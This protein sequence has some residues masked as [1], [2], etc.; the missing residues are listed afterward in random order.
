MRF[1]H[2]INKNTKKVYDPSDIS[3]NLILE[4]NRTIHAEDLERGDDQ[5]PFLS[6]LCVQAVSK[7]FEKKPVIEELHD[8]DKDYLLEILPTDVHLE[9]AIAVIE[10]D[11]YWQRRYENDY[12]MLLQRKYK[13]WTY[14]QLYIEKHITDLIET[15]P[16]QDQDEESFG[17][18]LE[19][20]R[21]YVKRLV[22][23]QL[24][25]WLPPL[26]MTEDEYPEIYPVDH[27]D[28]TLIL[29]KLT[30]IEELSVIFGMNAV[31]DNFC[32]KMF[33]LSE[34]DCSRI[35][36][37]IE[38]LH[39]LQTLRIH[40]SQL[41]DGH[42]RELMKSCLSNQVLTEL[43]LSHC[44]IGDQGALCVAKLI[45]VH[46]N[47]RIL[48]LNDNN[49]GKIGMEG[50][51][52]AILQ[53]N[54]C[55]LVRL[56]VGMNTLGHDG[57]MG[58]LRCLSRSNKPTEVCLNACMAE[59]KTPFFIALLIG[60][61]NTLEMLD[62]SSNWFGETGGDLLVKYLKYNTS[63]QRLDVRETDIT[64]KQYND[65]QKILRR[66]R[67]ESYDTEEDEEELIQVV[68]EGESL[69]EEEWEEEVERELGDQIIIIKE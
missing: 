19:V 17:T 47:L 15:L 65:I 26:T 61:N 63:L 25:R 13:S 57:F 33:K 8:A 41:G 2:T 28:F 20:C 18:L 22:I 16:P 5:I 56:E 31:G 58:V 1:P 67:K 9:L 68:E 64:E 37:A 66:N 62:I 7:S 46:P 29:Q 39:K 6:A 55:P 10:E 44:A 59:N 24:R 69:E 52:F 35:G 12:G 40:R 4:Q 53:K 3:K 34:L 36:S 43:D 45:T 32:W 51:G 14:K 11:F 48:K 60:A 50:I 38:N 21:D 30:E 42:C 49:I 54:S 23:T 27:I